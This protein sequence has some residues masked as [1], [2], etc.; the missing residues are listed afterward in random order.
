MLG[1]GLGILE[2]DAAPCGDEGDIYTLEVVAVT[3]LAHGVLLALEANSLAC[4]T[5]RGEEL[6]AVDLDRALGEDTEELLP[7]GATYSDDGYIH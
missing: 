5:C 3:Q 1:D 7:Y 6:E 4:A 2:G